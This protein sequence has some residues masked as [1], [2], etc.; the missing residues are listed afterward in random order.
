MAHK[1]KVSVPP[2]DLAHACNELLVYGNREAFVKLFIS[3]SAVVWIRKLK[4]ERS[5]RLVWL[6]CDAVMQ[7]YGRATDQASAL[8]GE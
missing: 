5:K 1:V 4:P 7:E 3:K 2:R 6:A 8:T